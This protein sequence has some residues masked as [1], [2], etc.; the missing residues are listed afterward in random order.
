MAHLVH[1]Q[2]MTRR[3]VEPRGTVAIKASVSR[4]GVLSVIG[5]LV[6]L[7]MELQPLLTPGVLDQVDPLRV[8]LFVLGR[9]GQATLIALVLFVE[10]G[11]PRARK[12]NR[13]LWRGALLI[14]VQPLGRSLLSHGL[15][16]LGGLAP[17]VAAA[18][19]DNTQ[20]GGW[21]MWLLTTSL[22]LPM[23]SGG[24]SIGDGL[25]RAGARPHKVILL[26]AALAGP[27]VTW[28][29]FAAQIS[30]ILDLSQVIG[31]LNLVSLLGLMATASVWLMIAARLV[32]GPREG[33]NPEAAWFIGFVAGTLL[34]MDRFGNA[35]IAIFDPQGTN[36]LLGALISGAGGVYPIILALAFAAGMARGTR[37]RRFLA[38]LTRLYVVNPTA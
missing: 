37:R 28:F 2:R 34:L 29:L 17:D 18:L 20:I 3:R 11:F 15:Q 10:L 36:T 30:Q 19:S 7:V 5:A 6:Y 32:M 4:W 8:V 12:A 35:A 26:I 1:R 13:W 23:L 14:G 38:P 33:T 21:A 9:L 24:L 16:A 25:A 27:A 22:V 31:W